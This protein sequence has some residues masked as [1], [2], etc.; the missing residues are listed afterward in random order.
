[1]MK[2]SQKFKWNDSQRNAFDEIK[3]AIAH[4]PVVVHLDYTNKFILYFY[5][6]GHTLSSMP[7]KKI[8]K[9]SKYIFLL[10]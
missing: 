2:G 1:M 8:R 10:W 4:A 9:V 3:N 7:C 5:A 6:L